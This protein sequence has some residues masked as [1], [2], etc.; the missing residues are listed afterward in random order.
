[1][2][3][4]PHVLI[5]LVDLVEEV[6]AGDQLIELEVAGAVQVE[7]PRHVV[8]RIAVTEQRAAQL[9][10]V[11]DQKPGVRMDGLLVT[12]PTAVIVTFRPCR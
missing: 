1:M 11:A 8:E 7:Q 5:G 10:L 3:L 2:F 6:P 9:A 4:P 12:W